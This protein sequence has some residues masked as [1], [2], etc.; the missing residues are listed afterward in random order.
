LAVSVAVGSKY[1]RL[2]SPSVRRCESER[3][4]KSACNLWKPRILRI[5][6]EVG[7]PVAVSVAVGSKC[8]REVLV[9]LSNRKNHF[10][11]SRSMY[12]QAA[13]AALTQSASTY[14]LYLPLRLP[15]PSARRLGTLCVQVR[16]DTIRIRGNPSHPSRS[17]YYQAPQADIAP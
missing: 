7:S 3:W 15:L 13:Q 11:P 6:M 14:N 12:Y 10:L 16:P 5:H 2:S 8:G 17:V 4:A 9:A 1:G